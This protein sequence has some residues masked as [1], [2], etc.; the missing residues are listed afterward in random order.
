MPSSNTDRVVLKNLLME[1]SIGIL[2]HERL[3]RQPVELEIH[4]FLDLRAAA[5]QERLD[6][7]LDYAA[8]AAALRELAASRHWD[9][10]ETFAEAA[11]ETAFHLG[12]VRRVELG[13]AKPLAVPNAR[14]EVWISRSR[15]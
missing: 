4:C 10:I 15:D 11:A 12:P 6:L 8:L 2:P 9:L 1:M 7:S 3:A 13:V 14:A 5:L